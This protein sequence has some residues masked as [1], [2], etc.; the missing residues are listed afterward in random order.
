MLSLYLKKCSMRRWGNWYIGL[1]DF[2]YF[3]FDNQKSQ[4]KCIRENCIW[5]SDW[6]WMAINY[7]NIR[8]D[9]P[10]PIVLEQWNSVSR[11]SCS[12]WRASK[13]IYRSGPCL[14]LIRKRNCEIPNE[15]EKNKQLL[16]SYVSHQMDIQHLVTHL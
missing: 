7:T 4:Q 15:K 5:L 16:N 2:C 14:K 3:Y 8:M 10:I 12:E 1:V 9:K 11:G 6:M 13:Q